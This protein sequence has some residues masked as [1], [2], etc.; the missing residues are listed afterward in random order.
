MF[1]ERLREMLW[2]EASQLFSCSRAQSTSENNKGQFRKLSA[3]KAHPMACPSAV[4]SWL[5]KVVVVTAFQDKTPCIDAGFL[6]R[7]Q[8]SLAWLFEYCSY[9]L[10]RGLFWVK[11]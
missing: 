4:L 11:D 3:R 6:H 5:E 9:S 7:M 2:P 8:N 1:T 10:V